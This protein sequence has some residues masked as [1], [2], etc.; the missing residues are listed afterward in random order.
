MNEAIISIAKNFKD[1]KEGSKQFEGFLI[2]KVVSELPDFKVELS[3]EI[4]LD[5]SHL[6]FSA[7]VL[8]DYEREFEIYDAEIQFTDENCGTTTTASAH[9]HGIASLNVD[10]ST[11]TAKGKMK[12]TDKL[13]IDDKLIL[14]PAGNDNMYIVIDKA[15][16][17]E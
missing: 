15:V 1:A 16:E 6:F 13:K 9:S 3:P 10:S 2:G 4:T 12:W 7:H 14:V 11:L 5:K 17:L 8:H